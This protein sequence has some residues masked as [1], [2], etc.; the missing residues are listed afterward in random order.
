MYFSIKFFW[1]Y[2]QTKKSR[3]EEKRQKLFE[4]KE[5]NEFQKIAKRNW[6]SKG[7][8]RLIGPNWMQ[9]FQHFFWNI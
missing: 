1:H 4:L 3:L 5:K 2:F 7:K 6:E 8:F 9:G